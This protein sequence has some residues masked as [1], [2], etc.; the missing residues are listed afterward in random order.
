MPPHYDADDELILLK[1]STTWETL[2]NAAEIRKH[3]VLNVAINPQSGIPIVK[4]HRL[5]YQTFTMKS[6]LER[7]Q[8]QNLKSQ[9]VL[10]R[11]IASV[12][13]FESG[14]EE[15]E[16]DGANL[17]YQN[18]NHKKRI[19]ISYFRKNAYF[20]TGENTRTKDLNL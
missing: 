15:N 6:K 20:V 14:A 13:E 1:S 4:Y 11:K 16:D 19:A 8:N 17:P 2:R 3:E 9:L 18:E 7:V 12:A 10:E 5:C